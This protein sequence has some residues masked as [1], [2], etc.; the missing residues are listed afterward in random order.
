M[1]MK[2][3]RQTL[4]QRVFLHV[5]TG[6]SLKSGTRQ[7]HQAKIY[8]SQVGSTVDTEMSIFM[9]LHVSEKINI[10]GAR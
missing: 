10:S 5:F 6:F 9:G 3:I 2:N 4:Q 1:E 7:I 8:V